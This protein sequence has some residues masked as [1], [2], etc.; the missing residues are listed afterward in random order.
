VKETTEILKNLHLISQLGLL[1]VGCI[2][3]SLAIGYY[4][5]SKF[6]HFPVWSITFLLLGILSGFWTIYKMIMK[7]FKTKG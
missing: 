5:D 2:A 7:V 3:G 6:G 1:M 4:I